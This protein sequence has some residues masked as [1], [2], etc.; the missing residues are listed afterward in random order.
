MVSNVREILKSEISRYIEMYCS[1]KGI[2]P[3]WEEPLVGFADAN[4]PGFPM[5]KVLV[6]AAH[7][8]PRDILP[9]ATVVVS[10]F[11]PFKESLAKENIG[12][13]T[14]ADSW[15]FAYVETNRLAEGL[16]EHLASVVRS[17]GYPA[18]SP[19]DVKRVE[20]TIVSRWSQRHIARMAGLGTFGLNNMLITD[21]GCCG[22]FYSIV[23]GLDVEP[24]GPLLEENCPYKANRSC[25]MCMKRC[26]SGALT[27]EGFNRHLCDGTS[28]ANS[29][30][31]EGVSVC[32]KCIV[33]MPCS[34]RNPRRRP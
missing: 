13:N 33:G 9:G 30:K 26:V 29:S 34:Y 5:L 21:N 14:P 24:D 17:M 16:G 20:G 2:E 19:K 18:V 7:H 12:G 23:T 25:G 15:G 4:D 10:Y 22:R 6:H 8:L 31:F 3:L 28:A 11:L 1:E 27:P 32:G